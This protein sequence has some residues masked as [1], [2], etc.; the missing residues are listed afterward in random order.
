MANVQMGKRMAF[1]GHEGAKCTETKVVAFRSVVAFVI[2]LS[3]FSIF[4]D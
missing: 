2:R 3:F 1:E 4:D